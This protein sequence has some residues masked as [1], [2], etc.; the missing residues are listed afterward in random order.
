[1]ALKTLWIPADRFLAVT[2]LTGDR[3]CNHGKGSSIPRTL[4]RLRSGE[5]K[6]ISLDAADKILIA[7]GLER[8]WHVP[9]EDGGLA[10]IYEDGKQYGFPN[11]GESSATMKI[12]RENCLLRAQVKR[13][14]A[15]RD[16]WRAEAA[17]WKRGAL[18]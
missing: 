15:S 1:M 18:E 3:A 8:Y 2:D 11:Q 10:D 4:H 7:L 9:Q 16:H 13:L 12:R 17:L 6:F 5:Q 14:T